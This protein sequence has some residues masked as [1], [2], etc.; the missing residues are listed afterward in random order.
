[1]EDGAAVYD[2]EER[3]FKF[4]L[5]IRRC[6]GGTKWSRE[7]W[8][9]VDQLLRSSGSVAANYIEANNAVSKSDFLFRIRLSKK[10]ASEC[11]LWLR[12][13]GETSDQESLKQS[14]RTLYKESDELAR[15]LATILRKSQN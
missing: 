13:L 8:T 12:L 11:R 3:T 15:I 6:V 9:D 10:E 4:A 7:Q 14:L 1:M 2:L 5:D